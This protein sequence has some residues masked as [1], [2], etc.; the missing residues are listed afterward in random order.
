MPSPKPLPHPAAP[1]FDFGTRDLEI[2]IG[3]GRH[4]HWAIILNHTMNV[5]LATKDDA[6]AIR[7]VHLSAFPENEN[8][9]V[10]KLAVD[11]LLET[12]A[13]PILSLVA[14]TDGKIVGHVAFS[15]VT[16]PSSAEFLG[17]LLAPL[18]VSPAHQKCGIGSR[19]IECGIER[20]AKTCGGILLVYGDPDYYG[21]F[22]FTVDA[23]IGYLPPYP[24]QY[25][26]GWQGMAF[27]KA[28][29]LTA[30]IHIACVSPLI[31]PALW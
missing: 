11:L 12:T 20:L 25:P 26:F 5:R 27:T 6:D 19:L 3:E 8:E 31:N 21:R 4:H 15:P 10:S 14:E 9:I 17:Y 22:G 23:A 18:A 16:M 2:T 13:H 30:P 7:G 1:P 28:C 24:L 29:P